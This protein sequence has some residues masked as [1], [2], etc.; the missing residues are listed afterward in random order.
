MI[1]SLISE[2]GIHSMS[3][4]IFIV[5]WWNVRNSEAVIQSILGTVCLMF[6]ATLFLVRSI[7]LLS[8]PFQS[9]APDPNSGGLKNEEKI[10]QFCAFNVIFP[11]K[12]ASFM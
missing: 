5:K 10:S 7:C 12:S 11:T 3:G 6:L 1:F 8:A 4:S 2:I 9:Q